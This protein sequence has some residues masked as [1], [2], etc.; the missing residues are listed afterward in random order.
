MCYNPTYSIFN[1]FLSRDIENTRV[2][3]FRENGRLHE[4]QK[5]QMYCVVLSH[6][7]LR[8]RV[9]VSFTELD[10]LSVPISKLLTPSPQFV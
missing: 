10:L 7:H 3:V 9:I 4:R 5:T 2:T 8:V 1:V 6:S